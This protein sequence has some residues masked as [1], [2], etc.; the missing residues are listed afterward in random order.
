VRVYAVLVSNLIVRS[1]FLTEFEKFNQVWKAYPPFN[2][3][4]GKQT[5]RKYKE[6][7]YSLWKN[8][9]DWKDEDGEDG[10]QINCKEKGTIYTVRNLME[11][12]GLLIRV[13]DYSTGHHTRTYHK[14]T[15]LFNLA[16]INSD[17]TYANWL[18]NP[19]SKDIIDDIYSDEFNNV[20]FDYVNKYL[21]TKN[22]KTKLQKLNY[23]IEKLY[24]I[25]KPML[26]Y[27]HDLA[28]R[29]NNSV[30]I[31]G[32]K[33][34]TFLYFND[35]GLPKGRPYSYFSNTLNPE[36]KHKKI[37]TSYQTR[38]DFLNANGLSDYY[39]VYDIKSEIPRVNYLFHTG[40]WRDD[41]FDFYQEIIN[42]YD[43]VIR[44]SG[45]L[46]RGETQRT[47][48]NDSMKQLFMRIYFGKGSDSASFGGRV[49]EKQKRLDNT[50][51]DDSGLTEL[52]LYQ[53]SL[54]YGWK[55]IKDDWFILCEKTREV[56]KPSIGNLIFW[57][58]FFIET[59]VRN[60]LLN[61]GK[62]VYNVYDGFY[63]NQ[64]ITEEIKELLK[65]KSKFVYEKF[66]LPIHLQ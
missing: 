65:I 10:F 1:I 8:H 59:E 13:S 30:N 50:K 11:E 29:L 34:K 15:D 24:R 56:V 14:N 26:E 64:D 62:H 39:E 58:S 40:E 47:H 46:D 20:K 43:K 6:V 22:L 16:F 25:S 2:G 18:N 19:K 48:S 61:R 7:I 52:E 36:K 57:Y 66:M 51:I 5:E 41:S 53:W 27:Y 44:Y 60:E 3:Q 12:S 37:D 9:R 23:N 55:V 31:P 45:R 49:Q 38:T 32:L 63:Y 21:K 42:E 28:L 33:L 54:E 35:E 17:Y 4:R